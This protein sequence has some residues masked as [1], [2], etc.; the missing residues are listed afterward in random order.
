MYVWRAKFLF[1]IHSIGLDIGRGF[2]GKK[3]EEKECNKPQQWMSIYYIFLPHRNKMRS[4][5]RHPTSH[6]HT[7]EKVYYMYA[8]MWVFVSSNKIT[9]KKDNFD[10]ENIHHHKRVRY[11]KGCAFYISCR[12][13]VHYLTCKWYLAWYSV[14]K[15]FANE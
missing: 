14:R 8:K 10:W 5:D 7:N 12:H 13:H 4:V 1:R 9:G 6:H 2:S 3:I 15:C 11:V